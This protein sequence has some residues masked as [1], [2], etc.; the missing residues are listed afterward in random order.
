ML[1]DLRC[2]RTIEGCAVRVVAVVH[3]RR[4]H[5]VLAGELQT[6]RLRIVAHDCAH[7]CRQLRLQQGLHVAAA[8]RDEDDQTLHA[9]AVCASPA[10][11]SRACRS[12]SMLRAR[13]EKTMAIA[14]SHYGLRLAG[15]LRADGADPPHRLAGLSQ[16]RA[17]RFSIVRGDHDDHADA[18]IEHPQHLLLRN[19]ALRLQPAEQR[20]PRPGALRRSRRSTPPARMRG[21]FS[22][23]PPPVM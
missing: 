1:V 21:T 8:T 17:C 12:A 15:P 23:M 6:R 9:V 2:E 11:G 19:A 3:D 7:R 10:T 13:L 18:A 20:R 4:M 22:T 14:L 16:Q 5:A